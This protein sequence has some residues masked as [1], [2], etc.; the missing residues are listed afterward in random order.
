[1]KKLIITSVILLGTLTITNA[2]SSETTA[3]SK[4][5]STTLRAVVQDDFKEV[6]VSELPQAVQEA[7]AKDFKGATVSKAYKNAKGEFK[8]VVSTA[9]GAKRTLL[10][11]SKG[12]WIKKQ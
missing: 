3:T 5:A 1:M 4:D 8:L 12:E 10:A 7:V 6:K 9:D 2:Q 11:N